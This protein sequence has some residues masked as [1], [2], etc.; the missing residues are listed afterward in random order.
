MAT[1]T[2]KRAEGAAREVR[3]KLEKG[4]GTLLGDEDLQLEGRRKERSGIREQEHAKTSER[5]KGSVEEA[6]GAVES[7]V[8]RAL[9]DDELYLAGKAREL[10]GATRKAVNL[11]RDVDDEEKE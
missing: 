1:N 3:G 10:E 6:A 2:R 8:G 11:P 5:V 4:V 7:G 9:D